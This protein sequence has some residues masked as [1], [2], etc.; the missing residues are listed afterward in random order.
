M[1]LLT[2]SLISSLREKRFF[3]KDGKQTHRFLEHVNALLQIH[4]KINIGPIQALSN[5]FFL[6]TGLYFRTEN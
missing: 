4:A 3:F 5:I 6:I 2:E 1:Q